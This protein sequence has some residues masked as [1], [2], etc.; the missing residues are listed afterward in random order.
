MTLAEGWKDEDSTGNSSGALCVGAGSDGSA[1]ACRVREGAGTVKRYL[2]TIEVAASEMPDALD[3][4]L[5]RVFIE[6]A[7]RD[8]NAEAMYVVS[9]EDV[10]ELGL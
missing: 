5:G 1:C 6:A 9:I 7:Q 2:V 8:L 4:D 10:R 3:I